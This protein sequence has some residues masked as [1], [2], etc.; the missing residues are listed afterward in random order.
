MYTGAIH[1]DV[2]HDWCLWL[3]PDVCHAR[4]DDGYH[5]LVLTLFLL[6][7]AHVRAL[8]YVPVYFQACKGAS[9]VGA[10]VDQLGVALVLAPSGIISGASV[11][12]TQKYR[13][14]LWLSWILLTLGT[15]LLSTLNED[16]PKGHAIGFEVLV[17]VGI[18]ILTTTTYFP[19]LAPGKSCSSV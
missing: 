10:G 8:D 1:I 12:K 13:P 14:Q 16:T 6:Y 7:F 11:N 4:G 9:P 2:Y 19:V 17:A 3:H 18:G 5:M 15:G